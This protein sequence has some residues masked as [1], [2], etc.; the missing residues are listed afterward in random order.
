MTLLNNTYMNDMKE[1]T[2]YLDQEWISI[3]SYKFKILVMI[4][5]LA[6]NHL[7]YRGK[8]K[9]MCEYLGI[10]N[11]SKN[12]TKLKQAIQE[13]AQENYLHYLIDGY[14]WTLTLTEYAEQERHIIRIKKSWVKGIQAYKAEKDANAVRWDKILK[15]L[16]YIWTAP[17][18]VTYYM[19]S[20]GTGLSESTVRKAIIALENLDIDD[21]E[22]NRKIRRLKNKSGQSYCVG[23]NMTIG[24]KFSS[25]NISDLIQRMK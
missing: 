12:T 24:I 20:D 6:E 25:Q 18:T 1:N 19:I 13:L 8:L 17:E 4:A 5:I 22:F 15:T 7:A 11:C 2:A 23:Q 14:T 9:D 10:S 16:M 21:F 3:E